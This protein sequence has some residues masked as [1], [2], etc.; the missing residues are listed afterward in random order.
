MLIRLMVFVLASSAAT[1]VRAQAPSGIGGAALVTASIRTN[2]TEVFIIDPTTGD[3]FNLTKAPPS[4]E[5]YPSWS[6]D[7]AGAAALRTA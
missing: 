3:A 6:P 4:E 1:A 2:D 5:R 7:N